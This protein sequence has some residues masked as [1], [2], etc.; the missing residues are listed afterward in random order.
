LAATARG[1]E[2]D[3]RF[4]GNYLACRPVR[5]PTYSGMHLAML[6]SAIGL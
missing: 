3:Q 5:H 4:L 1:D 6:G 2:S